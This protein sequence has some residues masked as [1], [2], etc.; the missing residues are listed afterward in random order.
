MEKLRSKYESTVSKPEGGEE[1]SQAY[2]V[3]LAAQKREE[4][5]REG[6]ELDTEIRR[7]EKEMKALEHT[8]NHL[9]VRNT[10]FRLSFQKA[11]MTGQDADELSNMQE[12]AKM[13]QDA[14]F[15]KKKELQ[16]LQTD[17]EE[18]MRRLE[19]VS[20]QAARLDE[21]ITHL[22][23]AKS[24]VESELAQQQEA[25][26]KADEKLEKLVSRHR[27]AN[28]DPDFPGEETLQEKLFKAEAYEA[29]TE[30]VLQ[31]LAQLSH[32]FPEIYDVL[33]VTLQKNGMQLPQGRAGTGQ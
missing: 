9:N 14:L 4:L 19:Q 30:A 6:D 10:Q 25:L 22:I 31:T 2:Y 17:Y 27:E 13:N 15:R 12:Q 23:N 24:Q 5:Q 1:H 21:Q 7:R 26:S 3:I 32:E 20:Q 28:E 11:D 8:L 16:R 18:D 33:N 29:N